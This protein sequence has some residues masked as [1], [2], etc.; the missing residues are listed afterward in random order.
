MP[1]LYSLTVNLS[2]L[3]DELG[4]IYQLTNRLPYLKYLKIDIERFYNGAINAPLLINENSSSIEHLVVYHHCPFE[5]LIRILSYTSK[6]THLYCANI[7]ESMR[8]SNYKHLIELKNLTHFTIGIDQIDFDE[9]EEFL[10]KISSPLKS[11]KVLIESSDMNY[12]DSHR[13][14]QLIR[15]HLPQL[16]KF[17]LRYT[18][19]I[20]EDFH[21]NSSHSLI[22]SFTSSF[23][24]NHQWTFS[25]MISDDHLIYSIHRYKYTPF[26]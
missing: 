17:I 13:W 9:F 25:L 16:N 1:C 20:D 8:E 11:L 22:K 6:L 2:C 15:K 14:E 12:L 24:R 19:I 10:L 26:S 23:W 18:D 7:M 4:D 3:S 21:M 5:Q